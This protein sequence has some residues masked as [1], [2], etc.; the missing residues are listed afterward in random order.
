VIWK[1]ELSELALELRNRINKTVKCKFFC[2]LHVLVLDSPE[3]RF[4]PHIN[5]RRSEL[6]IPGKMRKSRIISIL[7]DNQRNYLNKKQQVASIP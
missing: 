4:Y 3:K 7:E 5:S 6:F 1:A 2:H